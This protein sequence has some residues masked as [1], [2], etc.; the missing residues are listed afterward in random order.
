MLHLPA[1][2][3]PGGIQLPGVRF[4]VSGKNKTAANIE[5]VIIDNR[6]C[7]LN[8]SDINAKA[9]LLFVFVAPFVG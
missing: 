8:F 1:I 3:G 2:R 6:F 7:Y 4:Q 5:I 9:V